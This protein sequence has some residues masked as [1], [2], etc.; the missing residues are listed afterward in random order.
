V[1]LD[2]PQDGGP[3]GRDPFADPQGSASPDDPSSQR[4][5]RA[6]LRRKVSLKFKEFQG[7]VNEYS[8]NV[9]AGGMFI[10][11]S[12]PQPVGTVFDFELTL[13]DDYTLIHGLGEVVWVRQ[14]DEG[15]DRPPGMGVRFL[16]LDPGSRKLIDRMVAERLARGGGAGP[17]RE[18]H[19][20][21]I[22][23]AAQVGSLQDAAW[24]DDEE[25]A[26]PPRT[27]R[28][29]SDQLSS[30]AD[31]G[32]PP[33]A[34]QG[35]GAGDPPRPPI[36][37]E[38]ARPRNTGPS[39]YIYSR[40]YQG[41]GYSQGGDGG[42]KSRRVLVVLRVLVAVVAGVAAFVMLAP[43]TARSW[44]P[45]GGP[46]EGTLVARETGEDDADRPTE[47]SEPVAPEDARP[48]PQSERPPESLEGGT[49][50]GAAEDD[51]A[52]AAERGFFQSERPEEPAPAPA[53]AP[54]PA[55]A[56]PP[57][58]PAQ[59]EGATGGPV[60]RVL[61]VTWEEQAGATLVTVH[62]DGGL[63]EWAYSA[64]R[65]ASPPRELV[66]IDGIRNPFP[67]TTIP[68]GSPLVERVRLGY[69]P[70]GRTSQ[71]H[72]VVDLADPGARL[73]RS[74]VVGNELRLWITSGDD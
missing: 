27:V 49:E 65:L 44:L 60:S 11:T 38:P 42:D 55:P 46:E 16:S 68:V 1:S 23:T 61:N 34:P 43:E 20:A 59:P 51:A 47:P 17:L 33:G 32:E 8:E 74:E 62:L 6:D 36:F 22:A 25:E 52:D 70:E 57:D 54:E 12:S 35:S 10:R 53:P 28:V 14:R 72:V 9:S 7:F 39:P 2:D 41:S 30:I 64:S 18:P 63:Q 40:S 45:F 71:M 50:T 66:R 21:P 73:D 67:R 29:G 37:E 58:P 56:P 5:P 19:V 3:A 24:W 4:F 15:F 31:G 69:H 48:L 26:A 13:G